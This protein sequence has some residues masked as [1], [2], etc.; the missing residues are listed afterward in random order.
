[1]AGKLGKKGLGGGVDALFSEI[2]LDDSEN[3]VLELKISEVEPNKNQPRKYF[4]EEKLEVLAASIKEHGIVQ[5]IIVTKITSNRYQIVAGERRWR[6]AQLAGLDKV[7]AIVA[8]YSK[9]TVAEV[10]LIENLQREDLN[11]IEEANGY[12]TLMTQYKL[13]QEKISERIGKSRSA[14]ANSLRLLSLSSEIQAYLIS[15]EL[16]SGHARAILSL[17]T[18]ELQN[19]LAMKI[20][21]EGMNV[22]QAEKWVKDVQSDEK[23]VKEKT[24]VQLEIENIQ[25]KIADSLGTKVKI[26]HG[27]KKGKIEIEY[28]GNDDLERLIKIFGVKN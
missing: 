20:I 10:A 14:I 1:M 2:D 3:Q 21:S 13:T 28:Y 15:G 24:A 6:A 9:Q 23:P 25:S 18:E 22:R 4:D 19:K 27:A 17:P 7:K 16:T 26:S 5:P 11:P 8:D 12:Q